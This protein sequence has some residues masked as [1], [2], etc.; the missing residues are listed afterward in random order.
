MSSDHPPYKRDEGQRAA[1]GKASTRLPEPAC[2]DSTGFV[3]F[4]RAILQVLGQRC[5]RSEARGSQG[6]GSSCRE[7][8]ITGHLMCG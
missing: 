6:E 5:K 2:Q 1:V 7:S 3:G 8:L 4:S